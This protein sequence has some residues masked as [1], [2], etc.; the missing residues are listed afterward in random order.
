MQKF[1]ALA[2]HLPAAEYPSFMRTM[3]FSE[4]VT[5]PY[6]TT[7]YSKTYLGWNDIEGR[8]Y[9]I[10]KHYDT[11]HKSGT[12]YSWYE[13]QKIDASGG[14]RYEIHRMVAVHV[15]GFNCEEDCNDE[16][17]SAAS[18]QTLLTKAEAVEQLG[19]FDDQ[20]SRR[21]SID[22]DGAHTRKYFARYARTAKPP[23][24]GA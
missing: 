1:Q 21:L 24:P 17:I 4:E 14:P 12:R 13:A 20:L 9:C 18:G 16:R 15:P 8:R 11:H 23:A 6:T 2:N 10:T 19:K 7:T 22:T 5:M 3:R